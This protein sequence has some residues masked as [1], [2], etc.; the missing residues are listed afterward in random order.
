MK[1]PNLIAPLLAFACAAFLAVTPATGEEAA[2]GDA[3]R[4]AAGDV[5]PPPPADPRLE[6]LLGELEAQQQAARELIGELRTQAVEA[7]LSR[8]I[9]E[10]R[11]KLIEQA[12]ADQRDAEL[13]ALR[14]ANRLSL[15]LGIAFLVTGA[16]GASVVGFLLFRARQRTDELHAQ[17][18]LASNAAAPRR[19]ATVPG[20]LVAE[21]PRLAE[22]MARIEERMRALEA[23]AGA[24]A[25]PAPMPSAGPPGEGRKRLDLLL[26]DGVEHLKM[27]RLRE[28]L[29]CFESALRLDAS[30][31]EALLKAAKALEKLGR[32]DEAVDM[33]DRALSQDGNLTV[34]YLGKG[35]ALNKLQRF[36]ESLDCYE[37]ALGTRDGRL[38]PGPIVVRE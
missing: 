9:S 32:L 12:L 14:S 16:G 29:D 31:V 18:L 17:L 38:E 3:Q 23:T 5:P 22:L 28:A 8:D 1:L 7:R 21:D 26:H 35:S 27:E 2:P 6:K 10:A 24:T 36:E 11:L 13:A 15:A 37:R 4:A 34:A 33:Y 30:H 20:R 25:L 19:T